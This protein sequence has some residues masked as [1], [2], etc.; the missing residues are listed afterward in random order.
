MKGMGH[1]PM[2]EDPKNFLEYLLPILNRI[3]TGSQRSA[4]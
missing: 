4:A 3:K 2:S 1:V